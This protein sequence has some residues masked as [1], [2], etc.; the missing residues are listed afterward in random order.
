M[1]LNITLK[2]LVDSKG[3]KF[4]K[5]S[6]IVNILGDYNAFNEF[7][8]SKFIFKTFVNEGYL[9]KILFLHENQMPI[10]AENYIAE[11]YDKLGLRKDVSRYVINSLLFSLGYDIDVNIEK[12]SFEEIENTIIA[13]LVTGNHLTFKGIEIN[14]SLDDI[15]IQLENKGFSFI[16]NIEN[17]IVLEGDFAGFSNCEII[18]SYSPYINLVWRI[19]VLLPQ[20]SQWY[21]LKEEYFR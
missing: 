7:N 13:P 2:Q 17:G 3:Y 18:V 5:N 10:F 12:E 1:E 6:M 15:R 8:S 16:S 9:D 11:L 20:K 19:I 4:L 14:G 21:D